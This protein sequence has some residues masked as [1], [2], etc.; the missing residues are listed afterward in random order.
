[1]I[2]VSPPYFAGNC[3]QEMEFLD[4]TSIRDTRFGKFAKTPKV[5]GPRSCYQS[6]RAK[7]MS[8]LGVGRPSVGPSDWVLGCLAARILAQAK[9]ERCGGCCSACL[10]T[11]HEKRAQWRWQGWRRSQTLS[12]TM[13]RCL[14][15]VS[16]T[17]CSP[18]LGNCFAY[19][20]LKLVRR[21]K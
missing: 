16:S 3:C 4:I 19:I 18:L 6:H 17:H 11:E 2:S 8:L 5:S 15:S 10:G 7:N 21:L 9:E 13:P 14:G 1:M 12:L 20:F